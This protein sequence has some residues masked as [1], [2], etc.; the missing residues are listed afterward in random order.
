L[1]H[2]QAQTLSFTCESGPFANR[3]SLDYTTG[4]L[5]QEIFGILECCTCVLNHY[6]YYDVKV[7]SPQTLDQ[8][9]INAD[10]NGWFPTA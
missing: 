8:T 10:S 1:L 4:I 7:V 5:P 6:L 3:H 9:R 2:A